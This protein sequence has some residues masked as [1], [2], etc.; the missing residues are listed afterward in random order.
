MPLPQITLR[1]LRTAGTHKTTVIDRRLVFL[2]ESA[3]S[4]IPLNVDTAAD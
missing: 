4:T 2:A 3:I 1:K